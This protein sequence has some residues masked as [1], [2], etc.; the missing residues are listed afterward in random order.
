MAFILARLGVLKE[1]LI[2]AA[3]ILE[4]TL[5]IIISIKTGALMMWILRLRLA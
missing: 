4:V 5:F 2:A 1:T 3:L